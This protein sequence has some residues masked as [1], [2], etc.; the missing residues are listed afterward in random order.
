[1][2]PVDV[3]GRA[4]VFPG[5]TAKRPVVVVDGERLSAALADAGASITT[6]LER[7]LWA[8]GDA[9]AVAAF[10]ATS[11]LAAEDVRT[12]E[13]VRRETALATLT[14][15]F[16]Y[17]YAVGV[18]AA[19]LALACLLLYL[20][21]RQHSTEV[22]YVLARRMGLRR[23]T[24]RAA[25]AVE[26]AGMLAVAVVLGA[27]VALVAARL[28][29]PRLDPLPDVAPAPL[30]AAPIRVLTLVAGLAALAAVSGAALVQRRA[31][32]ARVTEVLRVAE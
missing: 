8:R 12:V 5:M 18:G 13:G 29:L 7:E 24:H 11:G 3:V 1:V 4:R 6:L 21:A 27:G 9:G 31:D 26:L 2:L 30:L 15:T 28:V 20:S 17:L 22:A 10:L 32:R 25:L 16:G 19:L 23:A 14:W